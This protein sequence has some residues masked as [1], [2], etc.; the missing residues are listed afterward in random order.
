MRR[1]WK[2]L[3]GTMLALSLA[4]PAW[5][6]TTWL[7]I[8][9]NDC[10]GFNTTGLST[11]PAPCCRAPASGGGNLCGQRLNIGDKFVRIVTLTA[12]TGATYTAPGG[13]ALNAAAIARIGLTNVTYGLCGGGTVGTTG[14]Q[15]VSF[16]LTA[17][18]AGAT[19]GAKVQLYQTGGTPAAP[20][21]AGGEAAN[22]YATA[23]LS[24]QCML[25]GY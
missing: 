11:G 21:A 12:G 18:T 5:G 25:I 20:I 17:P 23:N 13:D 6:A 9:D 10:T 8:S 7:V 2:R 1:W 3:V 16:N 4:A 24:L 19:W 14:G 22:G 15:E